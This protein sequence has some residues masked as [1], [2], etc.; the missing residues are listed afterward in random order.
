MDKGGAGGDRAPALTNN[1]GLRTSN[2]SQIAELIRNGTRGGMPAFPL[3]RKNF[4]RWRAGS[5]S[6]YVRIRY[7]ARGRCQRRRQFFSERDSARTATWSAEE[8]R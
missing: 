6:E 2:E 8:G 3:R 5:V 1:R 7:E 4:S